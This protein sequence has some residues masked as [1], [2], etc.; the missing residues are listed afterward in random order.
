MSWIDYKDDFDTTGGRIRIARQPRSGQALRP[1]FAGGIEPDKK[2]YSV[3]E[4]AELLRVD[5]Q[6]VKRKYLALDPDDDAP[7]P[8]DGWFR[9]PGGHIR[10]YEWV[11]SKIRG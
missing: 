7:I 3:S 1:G 2:V 8:F 4:V 5:A 11:I 6:T 10:I 9:L